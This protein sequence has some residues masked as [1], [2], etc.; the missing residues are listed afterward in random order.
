MERE[1]T[2]EEKSLVVH[3]KKKQ[4]NKTKQKQKQ[5]QSNIIL[6]YGCRELFSKFQHTLHKH[7]HTRTHEGARAHCLA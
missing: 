3:Q 1:T 2:D 4:Q 7:T 6:F 5:K